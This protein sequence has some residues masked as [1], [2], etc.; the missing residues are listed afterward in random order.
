M[1]LL[2]YFEFCNY[3]SEQRGFFCN[4]TYS[5]VGEKEQKTSTRVSESKK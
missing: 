2:T 1:N 5:L 4:R 3:S